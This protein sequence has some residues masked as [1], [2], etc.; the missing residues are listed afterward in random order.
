MGICLLIQNTCNELLPS[1]IHRSHWIDSR[2]ISEQSG[3]SYRSLS[4]RDAV[5]RM[6]YVFVA[7]AAYK[8]FSGSLLTSLSSS[9]FP[10][11]SFFTAPLRQDL[12][13]LLSVYVCVC[14]CVCVCV[15]VCVC[16]CVCVCECECECVC[17]C[18]TCSYVDCRGL[19]ALMSAGRPSAAL[20]L[21]LSHTLP[22]LH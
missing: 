18:V 22:P 17:V 11:P 3:R 20:Q 15:S 19:P 2:S 13:T 21:K 14:V 7:P 16:V 9:L 8:H 1:C 12:F 4:Y 5:S 6:P 10:I